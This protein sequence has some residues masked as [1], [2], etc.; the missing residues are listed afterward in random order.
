VPIAICLL[1]LAASVVARIVRPVHARGG[2]ETNQRP[3][4]LLQW[5]LL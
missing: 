1:P 3:R 4:R 2:H 5:A